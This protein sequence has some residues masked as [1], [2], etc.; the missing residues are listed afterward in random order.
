MSNQTIWEQRTIAAIYEV[1]RKGR[2]HLRPAPIES[3]VSQKKLPVDVDYELLVVNRGFNAW[4]LAFFES[5]N[6]EI[7]TP[8]CSVLLF[9]NPTVIEQRKRLACVVQANPNDRYLITNI[10]IPLLLQQNDPTLAAVRR[11]MQDYNVPACE[12]ML[13][14]ETAQAVSAIAPVRLQIAAN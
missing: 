5:E 1:R 4:L 10:V 9:F 12:V 11:S 13:P 8:T 2:S 14:D 3:L 7:V 6:E